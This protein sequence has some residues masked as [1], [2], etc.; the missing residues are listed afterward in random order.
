MVKIIWSPLAEKDLND[1]IDYIGQ[2]SPH[3]A[4][5][6]YDQIQENV[7]RLNLFPIIGRKVPELDE[8]NIRELI[9][10]KYRLIYYIL[11][12]NIKIVRIIHS[13]RLLEL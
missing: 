8:L 2:D 6:F 9:V 7:E 12:D 5:V 11:N 10:G 1:I 4:L 13:A 3:Y